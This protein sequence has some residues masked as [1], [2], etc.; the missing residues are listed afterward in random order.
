VLPSICRQIAQGAIV[1]GGC[2]VVRVV[3]G[4]TSVRRDFL[5]IAD[6]CC[7]YRALMLFGEPGEVYNICSGGT[8]RISE[9]ISMAAEVAGVR[10][11][12]DVCSQ[13]MRESDKAQAVIWGDSSRLR[14]LGWAPQVPMRDL[15]AQ[16]IEKCTP[17]A[18]AG[19][20]Q[21]GK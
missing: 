8:Y 10:A 3:A 6:V 18:G 4:N 7:A 17:V 11:E 9:L 20:M 14:S 5:A 19:V 1:T 2:Q 12:V 16:M 15:L 21:A 13:L